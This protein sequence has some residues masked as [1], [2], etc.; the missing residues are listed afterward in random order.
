MC[1]EA[2]Y[3]SEQ[4]EQPLCELATQDVGALYN[5]AI[6]ATKG[7][8]IPLME[9]WKPRSEK[10][11]LNGVGA[12]GQMMNDMTVLTSRNMQVLR[13]FHETHNSE[14]LMLPVQLGVDGAYKLN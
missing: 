8:V 12:N 2:L 9:A 1:G 14:A 5:F 6:T 3:K 10:P 11:D 7:Q 13:A 4:S